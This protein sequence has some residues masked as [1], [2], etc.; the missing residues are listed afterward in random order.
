MAPV[1][2]AELRRQCCGGTCAPM[3]PCVVGDAMPDADEP[4]PLK[5]WR[6]QRAVR[7]TR[8]F[9]ECVRELGGI[10]AE[11]ALIARLGPAIEDRP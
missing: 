9:A 2:E 7:Y 5:P 4:V 8:Q 1:E 6:A 11:A 3:P 10:S